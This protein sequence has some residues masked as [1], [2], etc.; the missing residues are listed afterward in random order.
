MSEDRKEI[1][2][3]GCNLHH[4]DI[5]YQEEKK[6]PAVRNRKELMA[7][8]YENQMSVVCWNPNESSLLRE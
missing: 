8:Q 6:K 4:V 5:K 2:T 3:K 7:K 1:K